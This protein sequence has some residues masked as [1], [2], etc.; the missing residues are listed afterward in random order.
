MFDTDGNGSIDVDEIAALL[1]KLGFPPA[2]A[3]IRELVREADRNQNGKLE[4][5]EFCAFLTQAKRSAGLSRAVEHE[6]DAF[7]SADGFITKEE[8]ASLTRTLGEALGE[9]ITDEE[10][11]DILALASCDCAPDCDCDDIRTADV[12]NAMLMPP[13]ERATAAAVRRERLDPAPR[14]HAVTPLL[15]APSCS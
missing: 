11:E 4:F 1:R 8:F 15:A 12:A 6:L 5:V 14:Q 7:S 10:I 9:A 13:D 3:K 2:E